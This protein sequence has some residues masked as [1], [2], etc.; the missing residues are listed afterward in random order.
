MENHKFSFVNNMADF[1]KAN[2][3]ELLTKLTIGTSVADYVSIFP[4][5]KHAEKVP[6]FD[7]GDIDSIVG[8]GHCST[9]FGDITMDEKT[10]TVADFHIQKG[11]CP[12]SLAKT[13]MGLRM[14]AGSYNEELGGGAE[15]RFVEDLIAKAAVFNER[16]WFQG[17]TAGGDEVDGINAQL[18]AASASTVN[19]TYSA[20][21]PSNAIEVAQSYV[22]NL[23]ESLK[24]TNTVMFLNRS[25]FQAFILALLNANY[26]NPQYDPSGAVV[27]PMAVQLPASNTLIVSSEIGSSRAMISYGQN[28]ALGTDVLTDS[29]QASSW[30]SADSQ[31]YR[32]SMKWRMGGLVFFPELVV[33]IA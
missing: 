2:E 20:M 4:N 26:Y 17:S 32:L 14:Q 31:E 18:D 16:K 27:T 12:E 9:T 19:V 6:V 1:I 28:L 30:W 25:D 8:T 3:T 29:A 7:T 15:E 23:P 21:T 33:R 13:L 10:L 5:I 24:Y 11:Y 22:L